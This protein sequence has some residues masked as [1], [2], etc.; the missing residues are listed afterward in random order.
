MTRPR[1]AARI[2]G[3][4]YLTITAS[5]LYA[6]LHVRGELIVPSDKAR[7]GANLIAQEHFF[8]TG[9]TAAVLVVLCNPPMGAIL[10]FLLR[11][12]NPLLALLALVF[13]TISTTIEAMNLLNY[14]APFFTFS[15]PE[16]HAAFSPEQIQALARGPIKLFGFTFTV[17]L[18]FFGVFCAL[19][20]YLILRSKFLPWFLGALM[21]AGGVAYLLNGITVFLDLPDIPHLFDVT[22]VAENALALWLVV[23]GVDEAKWRD[24]ASPAIQS[25]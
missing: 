24:Q 6:Y 25:S 16:Y 22:L 7:T 12:V 3:L 17:S 4:F 15:L 2:A 5:A 8:R 10:Y 14:A 9:L 13:I 1:L 19:T 18:S 21:M 11:V 20:G 23:F